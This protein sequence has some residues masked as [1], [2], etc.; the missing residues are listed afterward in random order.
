MVFVPSA[1]MSLRMRA[2]EPLP[3]ATTD[4]TDA[5]PMMIPSIVRN[6]RMRCAAIASVAMWN[7]STKR[8]RTARQ[9]SPSGALPA[10]ASLLRPAAHLRIHAIGDDLAIADLDD[11]LGVLRHGRDRASRG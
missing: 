1:L 10:E 11:A 7:A 3:S 9:C 4:T 5:M 6:V 8:S 2:R